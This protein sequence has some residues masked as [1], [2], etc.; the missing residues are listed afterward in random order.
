MW[1]PC[2]IWKSEIPENICDEI[3]NCSS[4]TN[5]HRG[6]TQQGE[7]DLERV[8]NIKFLNEEFNWINSLSLGYI[9]FANGA[10]FNYNLSYS[11]KEGVQLSRYSK[12]QF[13]SKHVDFNGNSK[14]K[15]HTRKLSMSIQLSDENSYDGGELILYYAGEKFVTPKLKGSVIVF[16]SRLTH[17]VTPVTDGERYSLVKWVHGDEPL[18]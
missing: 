8:V 6:L 15:A 3:I 13:Y 18:K 11:D 1:S 12:G 10:N 9:I 7:E 2:W 5:F 4:A 16:D 14:M 17:E